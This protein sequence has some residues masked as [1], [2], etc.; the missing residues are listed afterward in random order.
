MNKPNLIGISGY[1]GSGKDTVA[2]TIQYLTTEKGAN[3]FS[4]QDYLTDSSSYLYKGNNWQI[5]KYAGKLKQIAS[6]LTGIPIKKFE[7]QEFKKTYLGEEWNTIFPVID[8]ITKEKT[9][10]IF[11]R[12]TVR[13]LLQKLGT[14][15]MRDGL[16][17]NVW[18]NALFADYKP[19]ETSKFPI[20]EDSLI[21]PNWIISDLRFPNEFDAIKSRGGICIR[22]NRSLCIAGIKPTHPSEIAL[23]DHK[24]DY[25]I[26]NDGSIEDLV[27]EVEKML[28]HF[29][30]L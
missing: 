3:E 8:F 2:K 19:I 16:H 17:T 6:I 13:K 14:E 9:D 23:N 11:E 7:D 25:E 24:F 4:L 10:E 30:V 27:I 28:K 1:I 22:V 21:Y 20:T 12:M 29:K 18:V 26:Q 5:K 15:A